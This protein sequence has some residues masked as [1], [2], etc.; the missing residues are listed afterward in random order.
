MKDPSDDFICHLPGSCNERWGKSNP[1]WIATLLAELQKFIIAL[2]PIPFLYIPHIPPFAE[3]KGPSLFTFCL[4]GH[5]PHLRISLSH[6]SIPHFNK[7]VKLEDRNCM[8][9]SLCESTIYQHWCCLPFYHFSGFLLADEKS[10]THSNDH[11]HASSIVIDA[12]SRS[13]H[14]RWDLSL[15]FI[16]YWRNH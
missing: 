1:C 15:H 5:L 12:K 7:M 9:H 14:F 13:M 8:Q 3:L 16:S 2:L 10:L 4:Y 6:L 11:S